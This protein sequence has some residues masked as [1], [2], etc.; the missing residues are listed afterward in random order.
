MQHLCLYQSTNQV[1]L[2]SPI[3]S[4]IVSFHFKI[5]LKVQPIIIMVIFSTLTILN[6]YALLAKFTILIVLLKL[7]GL[8]KHLDS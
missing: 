1:F 7:L 4:Q 6:A 2:K 5:I 8:S 3:C